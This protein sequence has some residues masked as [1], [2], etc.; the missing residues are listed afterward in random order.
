M[1]YQRFEWK[2][3][4]RN[5]STDT[6]FELFVRKREDEVLPKEDEEIYFQGHGGPVWRGFFRIP[7]IFVVLLALAEI[8]LSI[9]VA[10]VNDA[11]GNLASWSGIVTGIF[12]LVAV[13]TSALDIANSIFY[14]TERRIIV[15]HRAVGVCVEY[16]L[17]HF[18]DCNE[19][20]RLTE[21]GSDI[22]LFG[23]SN[24]FVFDYLS[25]GNTSRSVFF[26]LLKKEDHPKVTQ[27]LAKIV[28]NYKMARANQYLTSSQDT[29]RE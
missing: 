7:Q 4:S 22:P 20:V 18:L 14:I 12:L 28:Y 11:W 6:W 21:P 15:Y 13:F 29:P 19:F 25:Q 1:W 8:E 2:P 5:S 27:A 24:C 23:Y 17:T 9:H 26:Y 16:T 3:G 10:C